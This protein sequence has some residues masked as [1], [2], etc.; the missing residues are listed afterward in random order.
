MK[1]KTQGREKMPESTYLG[2]E[3]LLKARRKI[4]TNFGKYLELHNT[5][6]L[7]NINYHYS[8]ATQVAQWVESA[9]NA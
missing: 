6:M 8:Q 3:E 9:C 5:K 2:L 7:F 4:Y 1:Q